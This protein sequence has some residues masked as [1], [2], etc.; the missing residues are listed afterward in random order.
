MQALTICRQLQTETQR[1][2]YLQTF[3]RSISGVRIARR[4]SYFYS[5]SNDHKQFQTI[6]LSKFLS[7]FRQVRQFLSRFLLLLFLTL[8]I[9]YKYLLKIEIR[10]CTF[11]TGSMPIRL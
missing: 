2:L 4:A 11:L 3:S 9:S 1:R 7:L 8:I 5:S 10:T 6:S